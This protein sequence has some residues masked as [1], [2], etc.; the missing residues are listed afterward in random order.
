MNHLIDN[1]LTKSPWNSGF[2]I[3]NAGKQG[4]HF[5]SDLPESLKKLVRCFCDVDSKKIGRCYQSYDPVLR[6]SG[7]KIPI[8]DFREAKS[9]IIVCMK[10][11]SKVLG[12]LVFLNFLDQRRICRHIF[13]NLKGFVNNSSLTIFWI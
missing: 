4:K 10:I 7:P 3:W 8:I 2:T 12:L 11:V 6:K 9:P 1:V 5:Y 13:L